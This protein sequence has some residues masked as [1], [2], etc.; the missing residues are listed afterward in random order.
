[1][2]T[3]AG[4]K[5]D[6]GKAPWHL[7]PF[8]ALR[9]IVAVLGFGAK[10]YGDRNWEGGMDWD[11]PFGALMRHMSAWWQRESADPETGFS[12]LWH[13]GCC[14]LFLIAYELRGIG[15]DTRPVIPASC[16]RQG[17]LGAAQCGAECGT[18]SCAQSEIAAITI[19]R[20]ECAVL[21][22]GTEAKESA[23]CA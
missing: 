20:Y 4:H 15:R 8:D 13:A 17:G 11:R 12:H 16:L 7:L 6:Q 2:E 3:V 18:A 19:R 1:M 5:N 9:A 14:I 22:M 21:H 10:K 23:Q